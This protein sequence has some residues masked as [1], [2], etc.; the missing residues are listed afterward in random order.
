MGILSG[1]V[2]KS[3][4]NICLLFILNFL[5][6]H[7][8]RYKFIEHDIITLL[9]RTYRT[10]ELKSIFKALIKPIILD[11]LFMKPK[12][13]TALLN[14]KFIFSLN[15]NLE[16]IYIPRCKVWI[17]LISVVSKMLY[18]RQKGLDFLEKETNSHLYK[19]LSIYEPWLKWVKIWV[20]SCNNNK[21]C[22]SEG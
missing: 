16:S 19:F 2:P 1:R 18:S 9:S 22:Q 13:L 6:M 3:F 15:F 14:I 21:F 5:F 4:K 10:S 20:I 17:V 7:F 12:F 11:C 8:M